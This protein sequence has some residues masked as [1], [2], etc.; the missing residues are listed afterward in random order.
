MIRRSNLFGLPFIVFYCV[1]KYTNVSVCPYGG[2]ISTLVS[3]LGKWSLSVFDF[4]DKVSHWPEIAHCARLASSEP[5]LYSL[6]S[7]EIINTS[8]LFQLFYPGLSNSGPQA[9]MSAGILLP[10]LFLQPIQL[11]VLINMVVL[12]HSHI[13][14]FTY[15]DCFCSTATE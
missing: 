8:Q 2:Q 10:T 11:S 13:H 3:F 4:W 12:K 9:S 15:Y 7:A 5:S 6:P 1:Y 14:I